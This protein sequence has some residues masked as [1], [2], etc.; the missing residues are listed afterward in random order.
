MQEEAA[1]YDEEDD[2]GDDDEKA[3]VP[4]SSLCRLG[5]TFLVSR[6]AAN[7]LRAHR[8]RS[9]SSGPSLLTPQKPPEP[10]FSVDE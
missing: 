2:D 8:L 3:L 1:E 7:A 6:F 5:A 10:D 9:A 4:P